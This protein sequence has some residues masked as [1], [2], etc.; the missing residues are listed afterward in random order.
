VE[1]MPGPPDPKAEEAAAAQLNALRGLLPMSLRLRPARETDVRISEASLTALGLIDDEPGA[2]LASL[3][4]S[5]IHGGG[6]IQ[7]LARW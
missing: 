5:E 4:P 6:H 7:H 3:R 2:V 1:Q